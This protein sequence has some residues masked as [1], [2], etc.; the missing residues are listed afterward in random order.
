M[1]YLPPF[2]A[3]ALT[4][5]GVCLDASG[6]PSNAPRAFIDGTGLGWQTLAEENFINVNCDTNTWTWTNGFVHC[7]GKPVGVTRSTV[8][9]TNF[10]L[11][12]QWRHLTSGG[13]SGVF[14][15]ATGMFFR[16]ARRR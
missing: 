13:N 4:A 5:L 1:K 14:V 7:L 6:Q 3:A 2:C 16:P 12:V 9:H 8:L 10:E 15:W 11:V